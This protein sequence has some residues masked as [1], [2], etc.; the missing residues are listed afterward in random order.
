MIVRRP[1]VLKSYLDNAVKRV[2]FINSG[3]LRICLFSVLYDEVG[4]MHIQVQWS[5]WQSHCENEL[6]AK[7]ATFF[8]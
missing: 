8:L 1:V 4:R 5:S 3:P 2:N 6:Q 7:L